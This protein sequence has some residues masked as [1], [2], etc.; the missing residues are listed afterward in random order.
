MSGHLLEEEILDLRTGQLLEQ[1]VRAV[2]EAHR[3][4]G[5]QVDAA[6]GVG[7]LADA[8][9]VGASDDQGAHPVLEHFLDRDDLPGDL[10]GA[11]EDDVE[12]LVE[13]DLR[14]DLQ[15]EVIDLRVQGDLHLA[16]A[17]LDVDGAVLVL[18]DDD[19]VRR[20][21]LGQLVDLL[22][23]RGDVVA[24]F[25]ECVG[26]L[27]VA[28]DRLGQLALRLEQPLFERAHPL[29]CLG[30]PP[31]EVLDLGDQRLDLFLWFLCHGSLLSLAE[32]NLGPASEHTHA[33]RVVRGT[34]P[35]SQNMTSFDAATYVDF[36]GT[37][38]ADV[39]AQSP[40]RRRPAA[41]RVFT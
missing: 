23:Q 15:L 6:D 8:L 40:I 38:A 33:P 20:R 14:A 30:Q 13:D 9:L 3:V 18:A 19:A 1:Q 39:Q 16:A 7:E 25:T 4:A 35:L 27:L 5:P 29:G 2:V 17:R 11:G 28:G 26:E 41:N 37:V 34:Y 10:R 22:A 31:S 24:R 36:P 21:G 32:P 12:A